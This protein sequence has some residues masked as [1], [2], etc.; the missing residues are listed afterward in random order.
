M[1]AETGRTRYFVRPD[2]AHIV[3]ICW[4]FALTG[5]TR[6]FVR[7]NLAHILRI[8]RIFAL[9]GRSRC[10]VRPDFAHIVKISRIFALN[11]ANEVARSPRLCTYRQDLLNFCAKRGERGTSF[12]P[13]SH[14]S[15][16]FV[17]F[18]RLNGAN[19]VLRSPRLCKKLLTPC[20]IENKACGAGAIPEQEASHALPD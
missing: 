18:L 11:R 9:T 13:T 2:F 19:K 4:I 12:A 6:C 5:R 20:R 10:F 15:S 16:G 8:F 1:C 3:R 7:P 17:G 14:T